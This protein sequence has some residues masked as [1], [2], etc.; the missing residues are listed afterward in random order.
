MTR[1]HLVVL[2]VLTMLGLC[3]CQREPDKAPSAVPMQIG[4]NP[5]AKAKDTDKPS[6]E[7]AVKS[8]EELCKEFAALKNANDPKADDLLGRVPEVPKQGV[9]QQEFE[10]LQTDFFLRCKFQIATVNPVPGQKNR[11]SLKTLD[12]VVAPRIPI[13]GKG[14][15][16]RNITGSRLIVE[17]RNGKIFGVR[18][19]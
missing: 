3:S 11:L 8:P 19:P 9:S 5:K 1:L 15:E 7:T 13:Q 16:D 14:S 10:A 6:S 4:K 18:T 2:L 12:T 17:V